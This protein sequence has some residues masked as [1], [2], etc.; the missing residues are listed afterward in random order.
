[1]GTHDSDMDELILEEIPTDRESIADRAVFTMNELGSDYLET[2]REKAGQTQQTSQLDSNNPPAKSRSSSFGE[3][4]RDFIRLLQLSKQREK[5]AAQE[6]AEKQ[7]QLAESL[8]RLVLSGRPSNTGSN[9]GSRRVTRSS[10]LQ[11][12]VPLD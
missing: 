12:R 2:P 10:A 1:M 5:V 3:R 9:A 4:N 7:R 11:G 8:Q 6:A